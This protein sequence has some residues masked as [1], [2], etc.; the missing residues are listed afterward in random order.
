M[1]HCFSLYIFTTC[2]SHFHVLCVLRFD[3]ITTKEIGK[4]LIDFLVF[5]FLSFVIMSIKKSHSICTKHTQDFHGFPN[6]PTN[7]KAPT[8]L[9]S[10]KQHRKTRAFVMDETLEWHIGPRWILFYVHRTGCVWFSFISLPFFENRGG[11][12]E[13]ESER[14]LRMWNESASFFPSCSSCATDNNIRHTIPDDCFSSRFA[15]AKKKG[16][17]KKRFISVIRPKS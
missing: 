13:K 16:K 17:H 8:D 15:K 4:N 11:K 10:N 3:S 12:K 14:I 1:S 9:G 7:V 5:F 2:F 6:P